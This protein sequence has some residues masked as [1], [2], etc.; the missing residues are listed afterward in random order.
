MKRR[1]YFRYKAPLTKNVR[2]VFLRVFVNTDP[3]YRRHDNQHKDIQHND[4]QHNDTYH[5]D[6]KYIALNVIYA[7]CRNRAAHIRHLCKKTVG[8]SCH[9]CLINTG[10][11]KMN[12]I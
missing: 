5:N 9:R 6:T 12:Y 1:D 7:E 8:L 11:K 10:V 4:T 2:K 3:A